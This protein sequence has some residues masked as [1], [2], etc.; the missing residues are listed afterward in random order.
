METLHFA[1]PVIACVKA[2]M[3]WGCGHFLGPK[4]QGMPFPLNCISHF[5]DNIEAPLIFL[6]QNILASYLCP[7]AGLPK[8]HI[9]ATILLICNGMDIPALATRLWHGALI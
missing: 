2:D 5:P 9:H 8:R 1:Y 3:H 7:D 4:I 6:I